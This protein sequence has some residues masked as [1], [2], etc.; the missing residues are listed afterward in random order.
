MTK[1]VRSPIAALAVAVSLAAPARADDLAGEWIFRGHGGEVRLLLR[2]DGTYVFEASKG[3]WKR[4]GARLVFTPSEEEETSYDLSLDGDKMTLSGGDLGAPVTFTRK[5]ERPKASSPEDEKAKAA[6]D[7]FS[8]KPQGAPRETTKLT[9]KFSGKTKTVKDKSCEVTVPESWTFQS[10]EKDGVTIMSVNPGLQATDIM[11][12]QI[13][14]WV[15]PVKHS[16][17]DKGFRD[18]VDE[19][20]DKVDPLFNSNG[21]SMK[22]EKTAILDAPGGLIARLDYKG[23]L[24]NQFVQ[25]QKATG[26][27][28]L[29]QRKMYDVAV[30]IV[31]L[32]GNEK[33]NTDEALAV[34]DSMKCLLKDRDPEK[35]KEILG[36]WIVPSKTGNT[37][38]TY[39]FAKDGTYKW[40]YESSYSGTFKNA[41]GDQTGA[42]GTAGQDDETGRYE[43][44]GDIIFFVSKK[45]EQGQRFEIGV[46]DK[47]KTFLRVGNTKFLK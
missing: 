13:I 3:K 2:A 32:D 5:G 18:R 10:Q 40:H 45:G 44:R 43:I 14:F 9:P 36:S 15:A 22:R 8:R 33:D 37:W 4:D 39:D 21:V 24:T 20:A 1:L 28:A 35:E 17:I 26:L 7:S 42:W 25:G 47:G 16:E 27:F 30:S 23:T 34:L 19:G 29:S 6:M 46:D 38:E 12:Q 31:T 11:K 41:G